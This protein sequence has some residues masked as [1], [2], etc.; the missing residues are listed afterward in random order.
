MEYGE[1]VKHFRELRGLSGRELAALVDL[2][3]SQIN[4]IEH[5][6]T[7]PS[8]ASLEKICWALNITMAQFFDVDDNLKLLPP[9][10][11]AFLTKKEN[12][13]LLREMQGMKKKGHSN[14]A[15]IEWLRSMTR[16]VEETIER[17]GLGIGEGKGVW[18]DEKHLPIE[19]RGK[20]TEE[21]KR[22]ILEMGIRE[23]GK[24]SHKNRD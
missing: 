19:H 18:V 9:E 20:Y 4:K 11:K 22:L 7:D 12:H 3:P 23:M 21:E 13:G 8:L 10:L 15:I 17:Y 6:K 14:E 24:L 5:D 2:D 1:R 16:A